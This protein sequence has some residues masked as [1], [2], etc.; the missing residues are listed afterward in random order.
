MVDSGV[1]MADHHGR[2]PFVVAGCDRDGDYAAR[3]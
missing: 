1:L 3:A 2:V